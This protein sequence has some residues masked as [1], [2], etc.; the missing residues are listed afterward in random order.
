MRSWK[1]MNKRAKRRNEQAVRRSRATSC[2]A[3]E[4]QDWRREFDFAYDRALIAEAGL[5]P[6]GEQP[7]GSFSARLARRDRG[8]LPDKAVDLMTVAR[9]QQKRSF[10][11]KW[12]GTNI[13]RGAK[14]NDIA[15]AWT[16]NGM[17]TGAN[18]EDLGYYT[19]TKSAEGPNCNQY[20]M[21]I[22]TFG[23]VQP[24]P[25]QICEFVRHFPAI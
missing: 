9:M 12:E 1:T 5:L 19:R 16:Q 7:Y 21:V 23:H 14:V 11:L 25:G 18:G 17:V 13:P 22:S 15:I 24:G 8:E 3:R 4:F 10:I 2:P 6:T 20:E